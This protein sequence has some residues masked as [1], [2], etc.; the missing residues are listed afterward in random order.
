MQQTNYKNALGI[1][2][3]S[4][5]IGVARISSIARMPEPLVTLLNDD[6]FPAELNK[7]VT[8]HDIDLLVVGLPRNMD[9]QETAQT[10]TTKDFVDNV[11][12]TSVLIPIIFQ[13][14]TLSSVEAEN[15]PPGTIKEKGL[16]AIAAAEILRYFDEQKHHDKI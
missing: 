2:V 7:L 5:R 1:D 8:I 11:L 13:D 15:F 14:E 9:G 16:D 4:K 12:R 6:N 3:G 10:K